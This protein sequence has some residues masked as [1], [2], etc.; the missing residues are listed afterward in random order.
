MAKKEKVAE[1]PPIATFT[2]RV[3]DS[4]TKEY[5]EGVIIDG[6]SA[7][8]Q[9][10]VIIPISPS[11]DIITSGGILEGSW[12]GVT[13][14]PKT[15]KTT[16]ALSFAANAQLPEYGARPVYY[17]KVEGRLSINHL[18]GIKGLNLDKGMFH[19]IQ[20]R[21]G[22]VLTA[23]DHLTIL[24]NIIRSVPGAVIIIDSI[25]ALCDE[26]EMTEGV[27]TE[28]RGGGAKL[29]SQFCRTANNVVPTN[30]S[31]IIGVTHLICNTSGM[32]AQ[33][34]ER[35]ARMWLYQKD[36]DLRTVGKK[37]WKAGERQIGLEIKWACN[38]SALGPPGMTI[39]SYLRF[40][41]GI[42]RLYEGLNLGIQANIIKQ[43]GAW[44]TFAYLDK[45]EHA[46]LND[47]EAAPKFQGAEK[48]YAALAERPDWAHALFREI[49]R[50]SGG[51]TGTDE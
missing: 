23:Q 43:A 4:I 26:R 51:L 36:Y 46:H 5:G 10:Q 12:V 31:I 29:F 32:G 38:T 18:K 11:H 30:R 3:Y 9:P 35:A 47:G 25:S 42:D 15:G 24:L 8:E 13:G 6:R 37:P 14:H 45:D 44:F 50:L 41:V 48:A 34:V 17:S 39:D 16:W 28:T 22:R 1:T 19:I 40:G 7:S 33:L 20:S 2:D 27:G 21:P 49:G